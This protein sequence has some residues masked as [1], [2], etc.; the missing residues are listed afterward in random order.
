MRWM[1]AGLLFALAVTLAIATAALRGQ[2]LRTEDQKNNFENRV[3]ESQPPIENHS[4]KLRIEFRFL[5]S[6]GE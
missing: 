3:H 5:I 1:I 4:S 2:I 6:V